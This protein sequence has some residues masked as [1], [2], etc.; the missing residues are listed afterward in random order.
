MSKKEKN[1]KKIKTK[2][3]EDL[4]QDHKY[5]IE[6]FDSQ[7]LFIS[8]GALGLSLSFIENLVS[9]ST[10]KYQWIFILSIWLFVISISFGFIAHYKSSRIIMN[11]IR[12]VDEDRLDDIKPDKFTPVINRLLTGIII[13]GILTLVLFVSINIIST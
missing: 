1:R 2:Y 5:S 8:S 10:A 11:Q 12:L 4:Y 7:A 6:K 3:I 9:L 13:L